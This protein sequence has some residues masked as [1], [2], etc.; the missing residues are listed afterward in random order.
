MRDLIGK[1]FPLADRF[2]RIVDVRQVAG[3]ALIY[4]EPMQAETAQAVRETGQ[5]LGASR[6]PSARAAFHYRDIAIH[7]QSAKSP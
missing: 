7:L 5:P 2:Y 6:A 4:A 1:S 3:D